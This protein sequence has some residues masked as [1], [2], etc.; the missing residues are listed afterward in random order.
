[1]RNRTLDTGRRDRLVRFSELTKT[2][3][4][5]VRARMKSPYGG[6]LYKVENY[7]VV[8]RKRY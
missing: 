6:Y 1:M 2:Q 8:W 5:D 4:R 3:K 7:Q